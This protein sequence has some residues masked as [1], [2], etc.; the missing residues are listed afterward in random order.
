MKILT[1][2]DLNIVTYTA[3]TTL[4]KTDSSK[5]VIM[6]VASGN[7]VTIPPNS[8]VSFAIGT[9]ISVIQ[10][11]AGQT[12]FVTG[13]GVTINSDTSKLKIA[14]QYSGATLIKTATNVWSL[15]GN[16]SA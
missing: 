12:S 11:G 5:L 2:V 16:L 13:S 4:V 14:T 10:T 9:Q 15:I 1:P 3:S 7:T 6:N 8:S